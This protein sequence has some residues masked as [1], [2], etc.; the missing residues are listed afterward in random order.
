MKKE[1]ALR[2]VS[3]GAWSERTNRRTLET[4]ERNGGDQRSRPVRSSPETCF[5]LRKILKL[6]NARLPAKT[7]EEY[8]V[9]GGK[10]WV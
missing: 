4:Q 9:K 6:I 7:P 2:T 5:I 3:R 10:V 8:S 1:L